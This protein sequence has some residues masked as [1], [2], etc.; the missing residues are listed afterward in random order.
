MTL[1]LT[2]PACNLGELSRSTLSAIAIE[3]HAAL[4]WESEMSPS[5]IQNVRN[6]QQIVGS[7]LTRRD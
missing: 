4:Q 7:L 6:R 3:L 1:H 5:E 2:C